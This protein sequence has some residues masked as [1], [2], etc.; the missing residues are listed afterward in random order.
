[1]HD[2]VWPVFSVFLVVL[3]GVGCKFLSKL[4]PCCRRS[5]IEGDRLAPEV[6]P[7]FVEAY[8]GG[9]IINDDDDY[10]MDQYEDLMDLEAAFLTAIDAAQTQEQAPFGAE[11][12]AFYH[13]T[14]FAVGAVPGE[15]CGRSSN[16][17][18]AQKSTVVVGAAQSRRASTK[19]ALPWRP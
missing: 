9:L 7:S 15:S 16:A 18:P 12:A 3:V 2:H 8:A 19:A 4:N 17:A 5:D 6:V 13:R 10:A 11:H 1:M 14:R